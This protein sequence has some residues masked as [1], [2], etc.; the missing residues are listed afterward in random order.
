MMYIYW[1]AGAGIGIGTGAGV[2]PKLKKIRER[3]L[4]NKVLVPV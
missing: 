3:K 4:L 1:G 2:A